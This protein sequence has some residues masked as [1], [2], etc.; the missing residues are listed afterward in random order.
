[1]K[2]NLTFLLDQVLILLTQFRDKCSL[3]GTH[4]GCEHGV[5]GACTI[6]VDN[7]PSERLS[8]LAVQA[9]GKDKDCRGSNFK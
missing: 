3:T 9:D 5:C 1:M 2:K 8:L 7:L 6:L 4:L